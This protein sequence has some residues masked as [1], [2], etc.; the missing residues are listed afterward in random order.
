MRGRPEVDLDRLFQIVGTQV[1]SPNAQLLSKPFSIR[2][3]EDQ[4]FQELRRQMREQDFDL[5]VRLAP[6]LG[7]RD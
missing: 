7:D 4:V 3:V 2:G 5:G 6:P 1:P